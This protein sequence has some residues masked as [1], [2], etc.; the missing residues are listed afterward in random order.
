[1]SDTSI[2]QP[3]TL[4]AVLSFNTSPN[5]TRVK[6][7]N[8]S[9]YYLRVYFGLGPPSRADSGGWHATVGPGSSTVLPVV[10]AATTRESLDLTN[11]QAAATYPGQVNVLPFLP[12][13]ATN[14]ISGVVTGAAYCYITSYYANEAPEPGGQ[15]E[16]FVQAAKQGRYQEVHGGQTGQ[17]GLQLVPLTQA[18][19]TDTLT[20]KL[21]NFTS[22]T[23]PNLYTAN[24]AGSSFVYVYVYW[25]WFKLRNL[26][27]NVAGCHANFRLYLT[28]SSDTIPAVNAQNIP[29]DVFLTAPNF[30]TDQL[31]YAPANPLVIGFSV[32]QNA[33]PSVAHVWLGLFS[34]VSS[35]SSPHPNVGQWEMVTAA[36]GLV[37][38]VNQSA[39]YDKPTQTLNNPPAWSTSNPQTY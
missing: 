20:V 24:A 19:T 14:P 9:S 26:G 37:D 18:S 23:A 32:A 16:A 4:G 5:I 33:L 6:V 28:N 27:P 31:V 3:L 8:D 10:G 36:H 17:T 39:L 35:G 2:V 25:L 34:F 15:V 13:G 29:L 11:S 12:V 22:S 21:L 1:M 38:T 30:G 7:H